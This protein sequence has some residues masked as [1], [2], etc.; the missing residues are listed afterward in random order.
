MILLDSLNTTLRVVEIIAAC[1]IVLIGWFT[2]GWFRLKTSDNF[3]LSE[4]TKVSILVAVRNEINTIAHLIADLMN[5]NYPTSLYEIILVDD[6]SDD[7]TYDRIREVY[8]SYNL[9]N[10]VLLRASGHGKKAAMAQ[11]LSEA[12]GDLILVTDAD[13]RISPNWIRCMVSYYE[14]NHPKMILGPVLLAPSKSIFERFQTLEHLSLIGSTAGATALAMPIMCNGAN[15]AYEREAAL[16]VAA[17]RNDAHLSSGDDLFL[18]QAIAK[19]FGAKSI[20]FIHNEQC[21]VT[22]APSKTVSD[23][24]RQRA[25]WVSKS[26]GYSSLSI[27]T[28]ALVVFLF[29]LSIVG[30]AVFSFFE[31]ALWAFVVLFLLLKTIIDFPLLYNMCAFMKQRKLIR[32]L[33]P[34][35][36]LYPFYVVLSAILGLFGKPIWKG[37]KVNEL[38]K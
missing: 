26:K 9:K 8:A 24:F 7:G 5:Q 34:L 37:R 11:A 33:I 38:I 35:E 27:I 20:Q 18:M 12:K 29:S 16:K 17:L 28:T 30:L 32:L 19:K 1:Y 14:K 4:A 21:V 22:T 2:Y 36:I 23:F 31:P 6:H 13:C 10:I 15:M 3:E 25:R